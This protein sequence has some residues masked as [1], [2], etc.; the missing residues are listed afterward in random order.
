MVESPYFHKNFL[1]CA[2]LFLFPR[3][4]WFWW[5]GCS[6][7]GHSSRVFPQSWIRCF[8]RP[9]RLTKDADLAYYGVYD[10]YANFTDSSDVLS[11]VY[12][13]V[14]AL[15]TPP[16]G[17]DAPCGCHNHAETSITVDASNSAAFYEAFPAWTYDS[18][19]TIGMETTEDDGQL[20][21]SVNLPPARNCVPDWALTMAPCTSQDPRTTGRQMP[22]L[23]TT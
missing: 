20:P 6:P 14:G 23:V 5:P 4:W 2:V 9:S 21:S 22:W 11:A 16:M 7:H 12:S 8:G 18:F 1:P 19:W 17:I 13:D 15:G 3:F 10:V